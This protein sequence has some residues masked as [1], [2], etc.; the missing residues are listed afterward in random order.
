MKKII[1]FFALC[2]MVF[3]SSYA[4][5]FNEIAEYQFTTPE[6]YKTEEPKVLLCAN[7]LF[8]QPSN[9]GE[10]YR[11]VSLGYILKWMEGTPD[12]TFDLDSK[13]L[14]LTKGNQ[15]LFG[16]YLAAMTKAVLENKGEALSGDQVYDKAVDILVDYCSDSNNKMKPSKKLKK[17][18]KSRKS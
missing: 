12:Y 15:D 3:S 10:L 8:N 7:Y 16:L 9:V 6:S 5:N 13:A 14:E 1:F 17:I 2:L 18:I 4:Q 11:Q